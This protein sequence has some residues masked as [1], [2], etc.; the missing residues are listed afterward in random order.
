ME[1]MSELLSSKKGVNHL[2]GNSFVNYLD[3]FNVL[4][5]NHSKIYD[6]YTYDQSDKKSYSF[7]IETKVEKHLISI[8]EQNPQSIILTGNAGDGKTRLC[9][10]IYN[11]FNSTDMTHWPD[12]GIVDLEFNRGTIR[13]VKDLSELKEEVITLELAKLQQSIK[14]N[15]HDKVYYLIAANEGKLT[16]FL[17]QNDSLNFLKQEVKQRFKDNSNND[18]VF[19]IINLLEVTS[20]LYVEKVLTEWNKEENWHACATCP[21]VNSCIIHLNHEKTS[22]PHV[23]ERLVEQYRLLD[24]LNTHI[25][26]REM[27]IHISYTL[28]GGFTCQDVL[29]SKYENLKDQ[30]E[31]PYYQNFYGHNIEQESFSEMRALKLFR[32][33]DPGNYSHSSID[34]FLLNGDISGNEELEQYHRNLINNDLDLYLGYF[35]KRLE[36]YRDHNKDSNDNLVEEW[37]NKLRRKFY[38]EFPVESYFDRNSLLPF[39]YIK[40]FDELFDNKSKQSQIRKDVIDGLNRAFSKRLLEG[41]S[42]LYS[43]S[44]NLMIYSTYSRGH[45]RIE[46]EMTR[47][48]LDHKPSKFTINVAGA[49]LPLNLYVFEYLMRLSSGDTYNIL[50]ED[51]E[52]LLDTF[53]NELIKNS[54]PDPYTLNILRLDKDKGLFI[55][56]F[57]EINE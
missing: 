2:N 32:E 41:S 54:E 21:K 51:V 8:F 39:E 1:K 14:T 30:I 42:E 28:T 5:P 55:Q 29:D 20:S 47:E 46:Q 16:K 24:Y 48:D 22:I 15:H 33:L 45:V 6:E 50:R 38:F 57:I 9:R 37:I 56:D 49:L 40:D 44:E 19:S 52:I 25:T 18:Y 17:S 13:I 34:D 7:Q 4:S 23:K 11:Y 12:S 35:T 26:M 10:S 36:I 3:Q 43:T 31:K 53:R 27:L